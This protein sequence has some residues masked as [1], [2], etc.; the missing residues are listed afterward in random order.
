MLLADFGVDEVRRAVV[1]MALHRGHLDPHLA[2]LPLTA[3]GV[4]RGIGA[5][6]VH[7]VTGYR[8]EDDWSGA[9]A[10]QFIFVP[11]AGIVVILFVD[12][13]RLLSERLDS[14]GGS[15]CGSTAR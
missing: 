8:H 12:T 5:P 9:A 4:A 6:V 11:I 3:D 10:N 7:V 1:T 15:G 13:S 2:T 14:R